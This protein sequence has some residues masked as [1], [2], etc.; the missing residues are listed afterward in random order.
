[1]LLSLVF[2]QIIF[3]FA[4]TKWHPIARRMPHFFW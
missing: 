4:R 1:V 2:D 3:A